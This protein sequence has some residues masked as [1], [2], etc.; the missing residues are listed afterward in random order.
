M[1]FEK[2]TIVISAT[3]E[4]ES[5][6]KTVDYIMSSCNSSDIQTLLIV[7]PGNAHKKCLDTIE[8][9]KLRYP[10]KVK[11]FVQRNPF[12]GGALRDSIEEVSSSH[13]LFTSADIPVNLESVPVMIKKSKKHPKTIVKI[14]RW[15]EKDSFVSYGFW[16]KIFNFLAQKF[17]RLVFNSDLTDFTTP[18]LIAPTEIYKNIIFREWNFPCLIEAV[19]IPVRLGFEIKEVP[20]KCFSRNEGKSKNS[21]IQTALYLK[22]ALRIRFTP[23]KKLYK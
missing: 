20:A 15:M 13:V 10:G 17:L 11:K 1:S 9:L 18:I 14:S 12:I 16:R 19:L 6:I 8:A 3:D 21:A 5:L 4:N 22:T 23:K 7:V 2:A